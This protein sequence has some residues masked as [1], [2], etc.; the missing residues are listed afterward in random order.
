MGKQSQGIG[1]EARITG[2]VA[3]SLMLGHSGERASSLQICSSFVDC[4]VG[5]GIFTVVFAVLLLRTQKTMRPRQI[6]STTMI[7]T[8]MAAISSPSLRADESMSLKTQPSG[9]AAALKVFALLN[10]WWHSDS[11]F[12]AAESESEPWHCSAWSSVLMS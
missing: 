12:V 6:R 7:G 3:R 5:C 4:A 8:I 11:V 2:K 10:S 9:H 1:A